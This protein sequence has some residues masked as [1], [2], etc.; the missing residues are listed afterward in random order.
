MSDPLLADGYRVRTEAIF[1][2][3]APVAV[4]L[5]RGPRS[6]YQLLLWHLDRDEVLAGQWMKGLVRLFD[7]SPD[8]RKLLYWAAQHH[9]GA[10][11]R[12]GGQVGPY[13]PARTRPLR[14]AKL[15]PGRKVPR[16]LRLQG[17]DA[18][19]R[20]V[21]G[22]WTAISTPPYFSALAIWPAI[23]HWTGGGAFLSQ[24]EVCLFEREDGLAPIQNVP[25]PQ[26]LSVGKVTPEQWA[27]GAALYSGHHARLD[28]TEE[29]RQVARSLRDAGARFVDW[30][31]IRSSDTMCFATDGRIH[32]LS[33]WK[34]VAPDARLHQATLVADLTGRR[35]E[36]LPAPLEAMRWE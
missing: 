11:R 1:A 34:S 9:V 26:W 12:F 27:Q 23:G 30:V 8:G 14:P 32:R 29:G 2:A 16:Y 28:A 21:E 7:L 18:R 3:T 20:N 17:T 4:I 36:L 19:V 6:H 25:V 31:D 33:G 15:K 24:R 13:D 10:S 35:F 5:R 22:T